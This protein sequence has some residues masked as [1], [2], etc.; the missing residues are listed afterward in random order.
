MWM[1]RFTSVKICISNGLKE[2]TI[3]S[4]KAQGAV[5]DS[6][7]LGDNIVLPDKARVGCVYKQ[8]ALKNGDTYTAKIKA[9]NEAAKA[10]TP[11]YKKV[12]RFYDKNSGYAL[13]DLIALYDE[14]IPLNEYTLIDP[15]NE[16][17]FTMVNWYIMIQLSKK[18][19]LIVKHKW[20]H[21]IQRYEE[22][23]IHTAT[24]LTYQLN[25]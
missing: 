2:K 12:Y 6:I 13:G 22:K 16:S 1:V 18:R 3:H 21:Y 4:L 25:Y 15:L 11:G 8:V 10:I 20:I 9:S 7:G 17:N 14:E 5:I 24:M 19:K 23:K